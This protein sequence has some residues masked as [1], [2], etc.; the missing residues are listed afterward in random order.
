MTTFENITAKNIKDY[1]E[2]AV[3]ILEKL[4]DEFFF[5]VPANYDESLL[6]NQLNKV[7]NGYEYIAFM[8]GVLHDA[9]KHIDAELKSLCENERMIV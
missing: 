8:V 1:T 2:T 4:H 7:L 5:N 3:N 6:D 9:I